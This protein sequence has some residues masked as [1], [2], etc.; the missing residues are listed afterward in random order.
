MP[1]IVRILWPLLRRTVAQWSGHKAPRLGAALAY[2]SVFS[3]GPLLVIAIAIAGWAFGADAARGEIVLQLRNLLGTA[4]AQAVETML[5]GADHPRQGLTAGAIGVATL[6]FAATGVALQFKDALNTIW[7]VEDTGRS[8]A[9]ALLRAYLFSIAMVLAVGFLLVV[10]L[11]VTAAAAA[12][13]RLATPFVPETSI[14]LVTFAASF[15][16]TATVFA[17][18]FKWLP[19]EPIDWGDVWLGAVLTAALFEAGKFL[20]GFYIGKMG[21]ESAYGAAASL[22]VVLVWVYYNAQIVLFGAEFTH[23]FAQQHGSRVRAEPARPQ[24]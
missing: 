9:W 12:A 2:Y 20:I 6:L 18:M 8:G 4:G 1:T 23:V 24:P 15:A 22:V 10:S 5:A 11:L 14:H 17:M 21:L 19:D 3:L 13:G 7:E 16:V